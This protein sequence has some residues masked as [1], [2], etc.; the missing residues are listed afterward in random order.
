MSKSSIQKRKL[1]KSERETRKN[2][3]KSFIILFIASVLFALPLIY[4]I[5]ASFKSPLDLQLH[6]DK[7]FP[8]GGEWTLEHYSG[9][10]WRD[11]QIDNMPYW[12]FNSLWS[13][14]LSVALTV[15]IDLITAYAIV[16]LKFKG[17]DIFI[18][19][20]YIWMAVP[21]VLGTAPSFAMF[22][23]GINSLQLMGAARYVWVYIWMIVPGVTGIF[24]LILMKNF[25]ESIP[26]DIVESAK[27]DGAS[28][29]KIFWRIIVPLARSTIML[30][31]LFTFVGSWNNLVFPQLILAGEDSHWSTVTVALM[32]F[33][34]GSS[35]ATVG[36]SMATSVFSLIPIIIIFIFTQNKMIDGLAS[37]GIKM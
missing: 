26:M 8:S 30:I 6:P 36:V 32:G 16:F 24:N 29:K 7:L 4:M 14:F 10:I 31:V 12:I 18:K 23:S 22:A 5:G 27:S 25:F 33:T 15:L 35:W 17:K 34:G 11:G 2:K 13:R 9:F 37:T 3:I 19:F 21:G 1:T 20:L 28:N